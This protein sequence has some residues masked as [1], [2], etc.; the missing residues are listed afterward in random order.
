LELLVQSGLTPLEA[1]RAATAVPAA[2]FHLQDRGR[3]ERGLRAD[4]LLV[5]GDPTE[6]ITSTRDIVAV[7]K[8]GVQTDRA[9]FLAEREAERKAEEAQKNAAPPEGSESGLISD[10]ESG[11]PDSRFGLGWSASTDQLIGGKSS[12]AIKVVDGGAGG[13]GKALEVEGEVVSGA[14]SWAGAIFF[15]GSEPMSPVNLSTR[16]AIA[17]WAQGDRDT[18]QV[19]VYSR[20]GGYIPRMRAFAVGPEWKKVTMPLAE[21]GTDGHDLTGLM[22][23]LSGRPGRFRFVVDGIALE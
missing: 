3:I 10:F 16:H 11:A 8:Q 23:G 15:P 6:D 22:I 4:L 17:F 1:L 14:V 18:C 19:M 13:S 5:R 7:W 2:A 20:S 21:F 12:A 9:A